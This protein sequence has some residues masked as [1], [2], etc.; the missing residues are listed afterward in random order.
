MKKVLS[1]MFVAVLILAG[2]GTST[3]TVTVLTN[4]TDLVDTLFKEYETNF[5]KD[6]PSIDVVF[7]PVENYDDV[8]AR[9]STGDYGDVLL[10]PGSVPS[11][12]FPDYFASLGTEEEVSK[13]YGFIDKNVVDGEVYGIP[14]ALNTKGM[15]Y[16]EKIFKDAG[17]TKYPETTEEAIKA[18]EMVKEKTDAIPLYTNYGDAWPLGEW[19]LSTVYG[20]SGD[21]SWR[22]EMLSEEAPFA[23][24]NPLNTSLN[25]L[26]Q[27]V[28]NGLVE[29]DPV[30][31][32]WDKSKMMVANGEVASL[33]IG[34]WVIP[35][36]QELDVDSS[37]VKVG[38]MPTKGADGKY[39]L[40]VAPDFSLAI[41]KNTENP[42]EAKLFQEYFLANYAKDNGLI[43]PKADFELPD[44]YNKNL[45]YNMTAATTLT[46]DEASK[47]ETLKQNSMIDLN[48]PTVSQNTIE[49]GLG[50]S[51]YETF[52]A[53]MDSLNKQW[54]DALKGA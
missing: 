38:P 36:I 5:E 37:N 41:N 48:A 15:V 29:E 2:C 35:Q 34:S 30:T 17:V 42:D 33:A 19:T 31:S 51:K 6:N 14:V 44:Y 11:S 21:Q 27:A 20:I 7:E 9:L 1:L 8:T 40:E 28:A 24:G 12:E 45:D 23:K 39:V 32:N 13:S 46:V 18:Y 22:S 25:F 3:K 50:T 26:Y 10:I 4:R 16:N 54:S 47:E 52:D 43:E 53:Y 49:V